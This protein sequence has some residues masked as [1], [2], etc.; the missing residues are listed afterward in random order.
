M[1]RGKKSAEKP[2]APVEDVELV[3]E[4]RSAYKS[5]SS[6]ANVRAIPDV[7]DG[8]KPVQRRIL[9]AIHK[10]G[11]KPSSPM[12]K[13]MQVVGETMGKYHPF[14]DA[15]TYD[16]LTTITA[17]P[18][19]E[20]KPFRRLVPFLEGQGNWGTLT[21]KPASAR[22][23]EC[24]IAVPGQY[25]LGIHKGSAVSEISEDTV[26]MVQN[27]S[28]TLEEPEV[29]PALYPSFIINGTEGIGAPAKTK[30]PSHNLR[31]VMNLAIKLV[32]TPNPRWETIKKIMPG[33]DLAADCDIFIEEEDG[34]PEY[35]K[36][37]RGSFIMRARFSLDRSK[38]IITV[39]GLPFRVSPEKVMSGIKAQIAKGELSPHLEVANHSDA[40]GV[41]IE[42]KLGKNDNIEDVLNRLLYLGNR[43]DGTGL[44]VP[45]PVASIGIVDSRIEV[46]PTIEGLRQWLRFRK[47]AILRRS[48]FR[49]EKA[50][51][52]LEIVLGN[53]KAVPLAE[54]IIDLV[55]KADD[56]S[57]A[58]REM[59]K[60]WG[61]TERQATSIL[62]MTI[63]QITKLGISRFEKEK[64]E[65]E[66]T[67]A[68]CSS[69]LSDPEVLNRV[70]KSE[71]GEVRDQLKEPRRS[72]IIYGDSTIAK[73]ETPAVK[74]PAVPLVLSKSPTGWIR[75][76][77]RAPRVLQVGTD[78]FTEF[79]RTS[80]QEMLEAVS[81]LGN[82]YRI[83]VDDIPNQAVKVSSMF[84]NLEPG[85][86]IVGTF[87]SSEEAGQDVLM[88]TSAGRVK[89]L[90]HE[91]YSFSHKRS[92]PTLPIDKKQNEKV[93]AAFPIA[94][95]QKF[96]LVS[97]HG[98]V[99]VMKDSSVVA[100]KGRAAGAMPGMRLSEEGAE[101]AWAGVVDDDSRLIYH[102][103][104]KDDVIGVLDF[105]DFGTVNRNV[106]GKRF[107]KTN[108]YQLERG[109]LVSARSN[110]LN[111]YD[112][113]DPEP[114]TFDFSTMD[115][116]RFPVVGTKPLMLNL[117]GIEDA[118]AIWSPLVEE[119]QD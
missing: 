26:D 109:T 118:T 74:V 73:P 5:F 79:T 96:A 56:R 81:N 93:I 99:S 6:T 27:Y 64:K 110:V 41:K 55:R 69:I 18:K 48:A 75:A 12:I 68:F 24:R 108:D 72:K 10:M 16:G 19:D 15:G 52:R 87:L 66:K 9:W 88:V 51:N 43:R 36:T 60:R 58:E 107:G 17:A 63:N 91:G 103:P 54:K 94:K 76:S 92:F 32:D 85:E 4:M 80:D 98:L 112:G 61:F 47:R 46:V 100:K 28:Q 117:E 20:G 25:M 84:Q 65:L 50:E 104:G 83:P 42:I 82:H 37:G 102:V 101:V 70:L 116:R 22:Y 7:R 97:D 29:L 114:K 77:K 44:Q 62:D 2:L 31:E 21:L 86:E 45:Y 3:D 113:I 34:V 1:A 59:I 23:T 90:L 89:R 115:K 111:W 39:V 71:I 13:A 67:I 14:G 35:Y 105:K 49:K 119:D 11:N 8:L 33:P 106:R 57:Q 95:G 38:N 53:L 78:Q 40:S 30:S